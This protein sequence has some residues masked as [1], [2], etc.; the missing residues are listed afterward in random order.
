MIRGEGQR[1]QCRTGRAC[2]WLGLAPRL[3]MRT[4]KAVRGGVREY[5]HA[6]QHIQS[7]EE[8]PGHAAR[9]GLSRDAVRL[10]TRQLVMGLRRLK[11][12]LRC[13][14]HPHHPLGLA[15]RLAAC[16]RLCCNNAAIGCNISAPSTRAQALANMRA[17][18]RAR[19]PAVEE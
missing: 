1:V 10:I 3:L 2:S 5:G 8:G 9:C 7:H 19:A 11:G 12:C 17:P 18:V 15:A 4:V 13:L 14:L 6:A 16:R